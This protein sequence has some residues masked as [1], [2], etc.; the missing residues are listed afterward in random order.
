MNNNL[1][2]IGYCYLQDGFLYASK[3]I[4][5]NNYILMSKFL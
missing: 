5:Q 1:L 2:I 4:E 3:E